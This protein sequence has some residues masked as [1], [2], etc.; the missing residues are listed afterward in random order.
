MWPEPTTGRSPKNDLDVGQGFR[1]TYEQS[2]FEAEQLVRATG[3]ELPWIVLRPSIVVGDRGQRLDL[4][5]NVMYW[6]LRALSTGL[7]KAVPALPEAPVD[8]VSV[9]YVADAI[10]ELSERPVELQQTFHL[11]AG[12]S[13]STWGEIVSL[14]CA[15]FPASRAQGGA[16][17]R[18]RRRRQHRSAAAA[19][20]SSIYF[21]TSRS[22][23]VFDNARTRTRL[24]QAGIHATPLREYLHRLLDF[25]T[26]SRWGKRPIRRADAFSGLMRCRIRLIRH[27]LRVR[28]T[29]CQDHR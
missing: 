21:P 3:E 8:I 1:I 23:T 5:F 24:A 27:R 15:L 16:A 14:A 9:D 2:K 25:A 17:V 18:V 13:A 19:E 20:A 22:L 6:P 7:F 11:T 12:E 10:L 28:R 4:A 26:R 29:A